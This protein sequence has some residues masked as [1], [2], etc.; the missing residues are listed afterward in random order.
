MGEKKQR[1]SV[2][3]PMKYGFLLEILEDEVIYCPASIVDHCMALNIWRYT[4][5]D[6]EYIQRLRVRHSL[7]RFSKNHGF[8]YEGDGLVFIENQAPVRGWFGWRWKAAL[9]N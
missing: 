6:P 1:L 9:T 7:A 8:P 4:G 5:S 2:G 3:R